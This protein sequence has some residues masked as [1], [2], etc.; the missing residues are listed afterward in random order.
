[1]DQ[2]RGR[3]VNAPGSPGLI[4]VSNRLPTRMQQA[5]DGWQALPCSGGLVT[6]LKPV[7]TRLRGTWLGWPGVAE[8]PDTEGLDW[9]VLLAR[10]DA[11]FTLGAVPLQADE[12]ELY[13]EGFANEIVWPLFHDRVGD[14]DFD[15][16]YW[17]AYLDV[18]RRFAD[19]VIAWS[20]PHDLVWVHDYHLF[21][22]GERVREAR[23]G[24]RMGFF[25]HIP[26]PPP[27]IFVRLPWWESVLTALLA[28][29]RLG[30]QTQRD[31]RNLHHCF[32]RLL[33]DA[34]VLADE[35][36][37]RVV[38]EGRSV[39]V[40]AHPIGIDARAWAEKARSDAVVDAA[41]ALRLRLR[42]TAVI[43]GVD[44][45]DYTKGLLERLDAYD[46]LL[47]RE[48]ALRRHAALVQVVVP[49]R[50]GVA[51]YQALK[52]D[53][54]QKI[55]AINGR[56]GTP[57]WTPVRYLYRSVPPDE[58]V[59]LY[60]I[61]RVCFVTSLKDGMNLVAKEY[62]ACQVDEPGALVLSRFAGAS[63]QLGGG[64]LLVNP[65]DIS[66][67]AQALGR[68]L[69]LP[70]RERARRMHQMQKVVRVHDV[71]HWVERCL[72]GLRGVPVRTAIPAAK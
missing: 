45:L 21:H 48:P 42:D 58:L 56:F 23:P 32:K 62:V 59:A 28:Y 34:E 13:Y 47:E 67:T 4:V 64:A 31:L 72:A 60:R 55:S 39:V 7:L 15:R 8:G 44:R 63:A 49:S 11:G 16:R 29:D 35:D 6:A 33:P 41:A 65:H 46:L 61:A 69:T 1:M 54:E 3:R 9:D 66:G 38:H 24:Q 53:L 2:P 70:E 22:V 20:R 17:R 30:V 26:F 36:Q 18:N 12:V 43:L 19:R 14:C 25:L 68:A 5:G 37:V 27:D 10:S 50:E 51:S 40:E 71:H 57:E 52:A